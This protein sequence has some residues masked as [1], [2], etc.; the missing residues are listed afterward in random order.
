[1]GRQRLLHLHGLEHHDQVALGHLVPVGRGDLHD[2]ALHGGGQG[3]AGGASCGR[4]AA[5]AALLAGLGLG[6]RRGAGGAGQLRHGDLQPLAADL[7]HHGLPLGLVRGGLGGRGERL[8]AVVEL[9]LD[10]PGVHRE[11]GPLRGGEGGI[12]D[13][14]AVER[15]HGGHALDGHLLQGT[16]GTLERLRTGGSG[17][18][19]L[20]QHGVKVPAHGLAGLHTG[21]HADARSGGD[22]ER[23][24]GAGG[25]HEVAPGVLAVDAEL[26]AVPAHLGVLV[27]QG[28]ATG[29]P[30]LLAHQVQARDLLGDG[31]LHLQARVDLQEGDGAVL[32]HQELARPG[33][34]VVGLAKD[35]LGGLVE[36]P[37]LFLAQERRGGLLHELLVAALQRAV[38]RGDDDHGAV[39]VREALGL[40]V[41][42][43]VQEALHE[44]LA[45]A[46]RGGGL[47][48]RGLVELGDGVPLADHLDAATAAAE[49]RLD[50]DGQTV[51]VRE[52]QNLLGGGDGVRGAGHLG[53]VHLLGDVPGRDLVT[54]L[55]DR[56]GRRADPREAG[57]DHG[58]GELGVL[59]EEAVARVDGVGTR[60]PCGVEH[61]VDPQVGVR[62]GGAAQGVGLVR[63][64]HVQCV[65]VRVRV[66]GHRGDALVT[67]GTDHAHRDLPPVGH[68]DL[69]EGAG[70]GGGL[71]LPRGGCHV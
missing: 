69:G 44:A 64:A 42:G 61:L 59:G 58:G 22:R 57:V 35:R 18:D 70:A 15:D 38:P 48:H 47:T 43:S 71:L 60:A 46:E 8:D 39:L 16:A 2:R 27:A 41:A 36:P 45:A 56:G 1:M 49:G 66:H 9:R 68:E 5:G 20:G 3:V 32:T 6:G 14:C 40:H 65:P 52:V 12:E 13:Y 33:A 50:R 28:L 10:P 31:V 23:G 54:Q 26:D 4:A 11:G 24:Q 37:V 51:L 19:E 67:G 63:H 34:L 62:G 29:D 17:D 55:G 25:G 21:V 7:H 53:R 30:E